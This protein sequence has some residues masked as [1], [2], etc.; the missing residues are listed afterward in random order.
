MTDKPLNERHFTVW[1][2]DDWPK[3]KSEDHDL[4][5]PALFALLHSELSKI[6]PGE[7]VSLTVRR[8]QND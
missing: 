4:M 2:D 8:P 1:W 3:E 6:P 7:Q 5:W